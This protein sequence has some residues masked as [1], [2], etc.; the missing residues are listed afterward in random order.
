ME[1]A[2][3]PR[4]PRPRRL[5]A[6]TSSFLV[7]ACLAGC[8]GGGGASHV[9]DGSSL[10]KD[11]VIAD[12]SGDYNQALIDE[13]KSCGVKGNIRDYIDQHR[14]LDRR[15]GSVNDDGS[16]T[17]EISEA[18]ESGELGPP[19]RI[20]VATVLLPSD[21]QTKLNAPSPALAYQLTC[22]TPL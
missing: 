17:F 2:R 16:R 1:K 3:A 4:A 21:V 6:T 15:Y 7:A 13:L 14:L 22:D 12:W 19:I 11:P 10:E 18:D 9:F 20:T 5:R 8:G